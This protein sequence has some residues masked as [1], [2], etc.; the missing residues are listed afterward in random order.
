MAGR[1]LPRNKFVGA[2]NGVG[3]LKTGDIKVNELAPEAQ[4]GRQVL[5][6][7][8]TKEPGE[9]SLCAERLLPCFAR[10]IRHAV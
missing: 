4:M 3:K 2:V 9:V 8:T 7:P 10:N 5:I 6:N 1:H